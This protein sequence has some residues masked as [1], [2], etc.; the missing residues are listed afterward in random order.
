MEFGH[1]I[2]SEIPESSSEAEFPPEPWPERVVIRTKSH[3]P[4]QIPAAPLPA[5]GDSL[6][7]ASGVPLGWSGVALGQAQPINADASGL[8]GYTSPNQGQDGT[9]IGDLP[10]D[11]ELLRVRGEAMRNEEVHK[12]V[13]WTTRKNYPIWVGISLPIPQSWRRISRRP[14]VGRG[15]GRYDNWR[16]ACRDC[17]RMA[18]GE[19]ERTFVREHDTR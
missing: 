16:E 4:P 17:L 14:V 10:P 7:T 3:A 11:P 6:S 2:N 19:I 13:S 15:T 1:R 5:S 8:A 12:M 9:Q 18:D